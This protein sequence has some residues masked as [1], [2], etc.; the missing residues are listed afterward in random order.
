MHI[1]IY[2]YI[3]YTV[4]AYIICNIYIH[5]D[6]YIHVHIT[7]AL[8]HYRTKLTEFEQSEILDYP[9]IWYLGI[10]AD[11]V[12]ARVGSAHNNGY[13]DEN[14]SYLKVG[15]AHLASFLL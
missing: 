11:K 5:V 9:E 12:Q 14:G 15:C 10:D 2:I 3:L 7:D 1:Y 8:K 4:Y 6:E 13:D